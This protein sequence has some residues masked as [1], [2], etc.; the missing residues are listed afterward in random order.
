MKE[1]FAKL[2]T[3]TGSLNGNR[4]VHQTGEVQKPAEAAPVMDFKES[5]LTPDQLKE[6][7]ASVDKSMADARIASRKMTKPKG[8]QYLEAKPMVVTN[9]TEKQ[10]AR[11]QK[12][13]EMVK[14]SGA[15]AAA[16]SPSM[17]RGLT[18][19]PEDE[20]L[21]ADAGN[22]G[23]KIESQPFVS[24]RPNPPSREK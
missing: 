7:Q 11:S 6:L 14:K 15:L 5:P 22:A 23:K 1:L 17:P 12:L 9:R 21:I 16:D 19:T 4:F 20:Q 18:L 24:N 2:S 8:D 13:I 10:K 3:T